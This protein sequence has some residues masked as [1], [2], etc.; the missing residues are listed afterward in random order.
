MQLPS[1][2]QAILTLLREQGGILASGDLTDHFDVSVQT[3]RKDLNDLSDM[4]LVKR[5]HG[6]ITLPV[7]SHNLSFANRC[8][9]NLRAKQ[10]IAERV[11]AQLPEGCSLFLGIGTTPQQVA[12]AMLHHP[13]AT[14]ITN[15]LNAA[16]ALCRN[17]RISTY[18]CGGRLRPSDQDL[19]GEDATAYLRR[20]QVNFGIFGIGGLSAEGAL[21]DFSPEESHI[22]QAILE[23]CE[24]RFLV[25][26]ASKYLRSAPV[27]T[28]HVKDIDRL[29]VDQL[30]S[31]FKTLCTQLDIDVVECT[32]GAQ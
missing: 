5:V 31:A 14:V 13:G 18:L 15:N 1:R 21:L 27:K 24:Q 12:E 26:D 10:R 19:M 16:L 6:G 3:I 28:G 23:N 22:S 11:V 25:A 20:F 17:N 30:P 2:Q 7:Q 9:I 8:V 29:F 32:E 4:G